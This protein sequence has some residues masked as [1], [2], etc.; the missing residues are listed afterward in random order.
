MAKSITRKINFLGRVKINEHDVVLQTYQSERCVGVTVAHLTLPEHDKRVKETPEWSSAD[1]ILRARDK[2]SDNYFEVSLG[3]VLEVRAKRNS[4]FHGEMPGFTDID[5][6]KFS[7]RVVGP[8][9]NVLASIDDFRADNDKP[10]DRDEIFQLRVQDLEEETWLIDWTAGSP[11]LVLDTEYAEYFM[12]S[13]FTHALVLPAAFREILSKAAQ[14][15]HEDGD[16]AEEW[17]DQ[18]IEYAQ[19][20]TNAGAFPYD[21][22]P[23]SSIVS[24]WV[25]GSVRRFARSYRLKTTLIEL[26]N[27]KAA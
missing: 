10:I 9:K 22:D 6:I 3:S 21:E 13:P 17:V 25:D 26:Q 1:V 5:N 14:A 24:D 18:F 7:I 20:Q 19:I 23:N 8:R 12:D 16:S 4:I 11:V 2:S 27:R 15:A